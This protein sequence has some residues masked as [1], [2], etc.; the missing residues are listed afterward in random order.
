VVIALGLGMLFDPLG[1]DLR[2]AALAVG[3]RLGTAV[4]VSVAV[5]VLFHLHRMDRVVLLLIAV[6]PLSFSSVTFAS[7]ENLD[8]PLATNGL[9]LSLVISL[10]LSL[11]TMLL[12][13]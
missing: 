8:V 6:A 2:R 9:S 13:V 4:V 5:V 12:V 10:V 7:L 11:V 1:G 3:T